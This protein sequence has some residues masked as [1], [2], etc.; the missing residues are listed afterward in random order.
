MI[1]PLYSS[2]GWKNK[3]CFNNNN[4]KYKVNILRIQKLNQW[5]VSQLQRLALTG[6]CVQEV[7]SSERW[8][9]GAESIRG[10]Y[11][12]VGSFSGEASQ[13]T[14]WGGEGV[15][16]DG[17]SIVVSGIQVFIKLK[18]LTVGILTSLPCSL[19]PPATQPCWS[20]QYSWWG[21]KQVGKQGTRSLHSQFH[22]WEESLAKGIF[23][24]TELCAL[25]VPWVRWKF[26]PFQCV[27]SKM[28]LLLYYWN[29]STGL[30]DSHK[31]TFVWWVGVKISTMWG[32]DSRKLLFH[33]LVDFILRE[34]IFC[35]NGSI[36][37]FC[38]ECM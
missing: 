2:L 36:S 16:A 13:V 27:Y 23:L 28:F 21:E 26:Y 12:S 4:N 22:L 35:E 15:G 9:W 17:V 31:S 37:T 30:L 8:G 7:S 5:I 18:A 25:G 1:A 29:F 3:L 34:A 33:H 38:L 14:P 11:R 19:P 10:A 32:D 24:G 20:L 6:G